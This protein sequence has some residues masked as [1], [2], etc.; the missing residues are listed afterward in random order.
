MAR[1]LLPGSSNLPAGQAAT[2]PGR[3]CGPALQAGM[4]IGSP[5][6]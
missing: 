1:A 2:R 3:A 5:F 6:G 4:T